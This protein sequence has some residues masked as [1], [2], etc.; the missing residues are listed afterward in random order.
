MPLKNTLSLEESLVESAKINYMHSRICKEVASNFKQNGIARKIESIPYRGVILGISSRRAYQEN[1][2]S[3]HMLS[4]VVSAKATIEEDKSI[5][6]VDIS[7]YP[8]LYALDAFEMYLRGRW[9]SYSE[10][11]N[12]INANNITALVDNGIIL[13][14]RNM[15][16]TDDSEVQHFFQKT[17]ESANER[18]KE[19]ISKKSDTLVVGITS[20]I[21]SKLTRAI[22]NGNALEDVGEKLISNVQEV[23]SK[24]PWLG[25]GA[26]MRTLLDKPGT[27]SVFYRLTKKHLGEVEPKV[28]MDA[29]GV[30]AVYVR[31]RQGIFQIEIPY[32]LF[33]KDISGY[34]KLVSK[35]IWLADT[36]GLGV[37][38][39]L[40]YA[41]SAAE[42]SNLRRTLEGLVRMSRK[43]R[44]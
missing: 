44:G 10:Q 13:S 36:Q 35:L 18:W 25:E 7:E 33:K 16:Q 40:A 38:A 8:K 43:M 32:Y 29:G 5:F 17:M 12:S 21:R 37:P 23:S 3:G 24:Y 19:I 30:V 28:L 11:I 4:L 14:R 27:R 34:E 20:S 42:Q 6:Q 41:R 22:A 2:F 9:I 1:V 31:S 15:P 26:L 39:P